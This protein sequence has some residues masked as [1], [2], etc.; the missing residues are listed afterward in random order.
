MTYLR[1][2]IPW[3]AF[4]ALSTVGWQW[5]ALAGLVIGVRLLL[6]DRKAG[7]AGDAQILE[8]S[9]VAYFAALTAFS[10]AVPHS[11]V[12]HYDG[13]ISFAWLALTAWGTLA[14]ARPFTLGIAKR[15]APEAVWGSPVFLR[16]N[17][18]LTRAWALSFTLTAAAVAACNAAHLNSAVEI[19][20]QV[21]G[22]VV[23]AVFTARYPKAAQA[24]LAAPATATS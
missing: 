22:F 11:P 10:F 9:T 6:L 3:I 19:A 18:V 24:R 4:A 2:F 20:C 1:G 21:A 5:G 13:A 16:I 12:E 17:V 15:Q 23:P 7:V 8:T 14:V